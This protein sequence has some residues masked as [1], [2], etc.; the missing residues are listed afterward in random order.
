[1]PK[2]S[3]EPVLSQEVLCAEYESVYRY[4]L[5]LCRSDSEAQD[6]TQETFLKAMKA[7][8]H[9]EGNSS[10]YTWL[11]AI[12]K[13]LWL[14]KCR[15]EQRVV[16]SSSCERPLPDNAV[17]P[18]QYVIDQDLSMRVHQVLHELNEPYKEVFSLRVFGQ[19]SFGQI[20]Q[21][22]SKT[23]SWARVTFHRA[24]KMI[25]EA[26]RKDGTL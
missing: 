26:T 22:F 24:R 15:K 18:E 25:I 1:M 10:L 12:A 11:C 23:E 7:A 2:H 16:S 13:N 20:A 6:L 21:L 8:D 5:S 9:F 17:S 19:L 4:V 14:N 3:G